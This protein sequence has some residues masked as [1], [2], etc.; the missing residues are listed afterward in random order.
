MYVIPETEEE[1]KIL[2]WE[3]RHDLPEFAR[4]EMRSSS[5]KRHLDCGHVID[6]SEPYR[7]HVRKERGCSGIIQETACEFCSRQD[8]RY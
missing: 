6:G 3:R 5:R 8:N 1:E 2:E 4:T 7:Y